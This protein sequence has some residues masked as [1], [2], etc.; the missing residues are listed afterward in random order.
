LLEKPQ[1]ITQRAPDNS[2]ELWRY[3]DGTIP[4]FAP[5]YF[6][7]HTLARKNLIDGIAAA[8]RGN[9]VFFSQDDQHLVLRHYRRGGL[10]RHFSNAHYI[11]TGMADTRALR[12]F[13]MLVHLQ[14]LCLPAPLPYACRVQRQGLFYKA[15]LIT[16]RL[17][18]KTLAQYLIE[19]AVQGRNGAIKTQQWTALG[20]I[21]ARFHAAG[22]YHADLNAHNILIEDNSRI[23]LLDFDRSCV[24]P[25]P[26]HPADSG[27]CIDNIRRLLRSIKKLAT[28]NSAVE[29][30]F[31]CE[32][33]W[34]KSFANADQGS[35]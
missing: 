20:K 34:R 5:D 17:P 4:V 11:Y 14:A 24:R 15:S 31:L 26:K 28:D 19:G 33:Q 2:N 18:G 23:A 21:I 27:W 12:E 32:A 7:E 6:D 3:I 9:T 25:L 1:I 35:A 30:F 22:I 16:Y 29:G 13:D 8:G 10:V